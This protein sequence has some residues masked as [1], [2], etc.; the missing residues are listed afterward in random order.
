MDKIDFRSQPD[1]QRIP[2]K[3][4]NKPWNSGIMNTIGKLRSSIGM[5]AALG[6]ISGT[7]ACGPVG[8]ED[9]YGDSAQIQGD[10][11]TGDF[12]SDSADNPGG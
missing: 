6:T 8:N 12:T 5:I 9:K 10:S 4:P 11:V 3:V 1:V 2:S 7:A